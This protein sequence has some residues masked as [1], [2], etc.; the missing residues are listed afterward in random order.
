MLIAGGRSS[1]AQLPSSRLDA[2]H[3]A[4]LKS[5]AVG[6]SWGAG[7]PR[8]CVGGGDVQG[9]S[10]LETACQETATHGAVTQPSKAHPRSIP[11]E[12]M[13]TRAHAHASFY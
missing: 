1:K 8:L 9:H 12:G 7:W 11:E 3:A 4:A 2:P 5:R 6:K 13:F 10:H